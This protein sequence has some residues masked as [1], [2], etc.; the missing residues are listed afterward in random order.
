MAPIRNQGQRGTCVA[1]AVTAGHE[2]SRGPA[3]PDDLSEEALYWGCKTTDGNWHGG[4]K[5]TS[6]HT[7]IERWGQPL[8]TRWPYNDAQVDGVEI[9]LPVGMKMSDWHRSGL[10]RV[11]TAIA[12]LQALLAAGT[13]VVLG[14]T[15]FDTL[16]RPGRDG[17]VQDPPPRAPQRGLH[18]VLAVGREPGSILI[19]NSWGPGWALGGYG[20]ITDTY[21]N[22]FVVEAW[23]VDDAASGSAGTT[24]KS[25]SQEQGAIYG[26]P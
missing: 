6:A 17:R 12:D 14:L 10:R 23:I 2:V 21:V 20:W 16:F 15:V 11:G 5:F 25:A 13:P 8:E 9:K 26:S 4:T 18:A 22:K 7:A 19:R 3:I 1:F 24:S